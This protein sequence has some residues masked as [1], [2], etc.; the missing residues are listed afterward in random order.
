[1]RS[2]RHSLVLFLALAGL[3]AGCHADR[4]ATRAPA[5]PQTAET[6][7]ARYQR[8]ADY[9][10]QHYQYYVDTGRARNEEQAK[11]LAGYQW[12]RSA[13]QQRFGDS[14]QV[15]NARWSS[16]DARKREQEAFEEDLAKTLKN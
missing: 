6:P 16:E 4:R 14:S 3:L 12:D 11:V 15:T 9:V 8:R 13:Q 2:P 1:M 5:Y 7:E 10:N